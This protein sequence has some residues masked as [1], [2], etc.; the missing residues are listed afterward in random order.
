M[1]D[2]PG[3]RPYRSLSLAH[4]SQCD[5][6]NS[7]EGVDPLAAGHFGSG[8]AGGHRYF[9]RDRRTSVKVGSRPAGVAKHIEFRLRPTTRDVR[10]AIA[11]GC[12]V[13]LGIVGN[14]GCVG[15]TW[16]G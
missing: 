3:M 12:R 15:P 2:A 10:K 11:H 6:V 14:G 13:S 7:I 16:L 1:G 5:S 9:P 4:N 8:G